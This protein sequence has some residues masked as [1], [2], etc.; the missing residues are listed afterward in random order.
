MG[1]KVRL[2]LA[3]FLCLPLSVL[4]AERRTAIL[5]INQPCVIEELDSELP[6]APQKA[7]QIRQRLLDT[8]EG[9]ALVGRVRAR[10]MGIVEAVRATGA[11]I[12]GQ[13]DVVLNSIHVLATEEQLQALRRI[14]GVV[15]AEWAREYRL[16]LD[17]AVPLIQ[18]PLAWQVLAINGEEYAGRGVKIAVIDTG[19]DPSHPMFQDISLT[20]PTGYPKYDSGFLQYTNSKIIVARSF[21]A[22]CSSSPPTGCTP[23]DN[24]G[25]GTFAA[26]VAAGNLAYSS[27]A[28]GYIRGVA[29]KAFLGN[30]RVFPTTGTA[31]ENDVLSAINQAV[32]D[33][34]DI[35]NMSV[36]TDAQDATL[37]DILAVQRATTANVLVVASAGNSGPNGDLAWPRARTVA[38][39]C[40]QSEV[41]CVGATTNARIFA[42]SVNI[43][44][45]AAVPASLASLLA[46][47]SNTTNLSTV[48]G[49][50]PAV[51]IADMD[52]TGLACSAASFSSGSLTGRMALILRGQCTFSVK[53]SNVSAAGAVGAI[54][55]DN[56]VALAPVSM[57]TTGSSIPAMAILNADGLALKAFLAGNAA[58]AAFDPTQRAHAFPPDIVTDFSSRGPSIKLAIKPDLVA[59]GDSILSATQ[60]VNSGGEMYKSSGFT[61]ASGTS[62]SSPMTVGA[63]ALV[64]QVHPSW[65]ALQIK[66]AVVNTA[67]KI[68][69][70]TEEGAAASVLSSGAGRVD[71]LA[72][73]NATILAN[74][75]S[76]SFDNQ[77]YGAPTT[78]GTAPFGV[79]NMGAG[80]DTFNLAI[81]PART[82]P[83]VSLAL[84]NTVLSSLAAGSSATVTLRATYSAPPASSSEGMIE[85]TSQASGAVIRVPYWVSAVK[86]VVSTSGIVNAANYSA[87]AGIAPGTLIAI[88]GSALGSS[89]GAQASTF[90]LPYQL[91]GAEV[92]LYG[93]SLPLLY[94]GSSQVNAVIPYNATVG[95][96]GVEVAVDGALAE[97]ANATT[98]YAL[99][100]V[101]FSPALFSMDS[102]GKGLGAIARADG[103]V[104][105][106]DNPAQPGEMVSLYGTGLGAVDNAPALGR[107]TPLTPLAPTKTTPTVTVG[108]Q[109]A[110]VQ[111][112]GLAPTFIGLYQINVVLPTNLTPAPPGDYPVVLTIDGAQSNTVTISIR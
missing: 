86:P 101:P 82:C 14:S 28:A 42:G 58:T 17:Y 30:Y 15:S 8:Q 4:A 100:I 70:N 84:D 5:V 80:T 63:A 18:A 39:P 56:V 20:P 43:S 25:H 68:T 54:I 12:I 62:F 24:W 67:A 3:V 105:T 48:F 88:F 72:S 69:T 83:T 38:W 97:G 96:G 40:F 93:S 74:P 55:Y 110:T 32:T 16:M 64:K 49:P 87:A 29:P 52:P 107:P 36:G 95:T 109:P 106:K 33:G 76:L 13:T 61:V 23:L 46:A 44:S 21:L 41:L 37:A 111:W 85:I 2:F 81:V 6:E 1:F 45:T 47:P 98:L 31:R 102:S 94:A 99:P 89:P 59:P 7:A 79:T 77:T 35:I 112:A 108:G 92:R 9:A 22:A 53:L 26:A 50:Y 103:T 78:P 60:T 71:A 51:D 91:G 75:A 73:V 34:M 57:D 65:T 27:L 10:R 66:S 90:P 104:L 11:E 19:I